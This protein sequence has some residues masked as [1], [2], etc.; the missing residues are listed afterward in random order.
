M[1]AGQF[2]NPAN[3]EV[4]RRTTAEE[5]WR[6]TDGHVDVFVAGV[7]TGGTISGVSDVLKQRNPELHS[8]ALE[9]TTS[10]VMSGGEPG[11]GNLIQGIGPGFFPDVLRMDLIDVE[12]EGPADDIR[13]AL[14]AEHADDA[15]FLHAAERRI[16]GLVCQ[17]QPLGSVCCGEN[18]TLTEKL[19]NLDRRS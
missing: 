13:I 19:M 4:H 8:V 17:V 12:Q 16:D 5:I 15:E 9:P 6:D 14:R 1:Q 2:A 11:P 18:R 10:P 3:P 7:G